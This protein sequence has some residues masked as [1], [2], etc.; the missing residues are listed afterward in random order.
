[1]NSAGY[2]F[3]P[4]LWLH[5]L[6]PLAS[7]TPKVQRR[8]GIASCLHSDAN[9][10]HREHNQLARHQST[11]C[12]PL[13]RASILGLSASSRPMHHLCSQPPV[14]PLEPAS[15]LSLGVIWQGL[16]RGRASGRTECTSV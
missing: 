9:L 14:L 2:L 6:D 3:L 8:I 15:R 4:G 13:V 11:S 10:S 12:S 7:R 5:E 1:M 16:T